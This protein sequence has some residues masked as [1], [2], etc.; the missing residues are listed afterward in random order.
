MKL[1]SILPMK[2]NRNN[3]LIFLLSSMLPLCAFAQEGG[4]LEDLE[5]EQQNQP[6]TQ[7]VEAVFKATRI[8]NGQSVE[9]RKEGVL[10]FLI[11]HRFGRLNTGAYEFFGLDDANMRMGL[12]YAFLD[13]LTVGIGRSSF[14]KTYDGFVKL[15]LLRQQEGVKNI[16]VSMVGFASLA[17]NSL[18]DAS[19]ERSMPFTGR[20]DYTYQLLIAR[21]FSS[22]FSLQLTPTLVHRNLV[23]KAE[24]SNNLYAMGVGARIKMTKRVSLNAEYF[25]RFNVSEDE[26]IYYNPVAIG[27]DIETGGHVFQLHLTNAQAMVEEGFLTETTGNFFGGDIHFGFNISRV[28]ELK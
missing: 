6:D 26:E 9:L 22:V 11:A 4:L 18:K 8:I 20:M 14:E 25:Y 2:P 27:F 24:T 1:L 21:K 23:E 13:D 10:V 15:S 16:P 12:E 7:Q 17:I 28:F 19:P 3:I 5:K